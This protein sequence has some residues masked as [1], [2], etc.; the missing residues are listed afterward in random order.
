MTL[1]LIRSGLCLLVLLAA[2]R[3]LLEKEKMLHFNRA[4]LLFSL[5]FS[6]IVPFIPLTN[7]FQSAQRNNEIPGLLVEIDHLIAPPHP[8]AGTVLQPSHSIPVSAI[9][10]IAYCL[11]TLGFLIRFIRHLYLIR[12]RIHTNQRIRLKEAWLVLVPE[13]VVS[14]TFYTT[15]FINE[16]V[17]KE[18]RLEQEVLMHELAHVKQRH[19]ID[20]LLVEAL[21]SFF[22]FNPLLILYKR[23]IQLNHEF[24]ADEAVTAVCEDP[25]EYQYLLLSKMLPTDHL[26]LSSP[27]NYKIAKKRLIM[28]TKTYNKK[29]ALVKKLTV[30]PLLL[31][32]LFFFST[33]INAQQEQSDSSKHPDR[34][35]SGTEILGNN[36]Y[37]VINGK[38][39][40][41]DILMKISPA[42]ISSTSAFS[43]Q[44]SIRRYGPTASDGAVEIT[45]VKEG[46]SYATPTER[47]N[48]AKERAV[49]TG[50]YHRISLKKED[51]S[52]FDELIINYPE[53]KG[54][55]A[56]WG[57]TG[58]KVGFLV[59]DKLYTEDQIGELEKLLNSTKRQGPFGVGGND[60]KKVPGLDLSSYK[61]IFYF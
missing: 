40:P 8:A 18:Q 12:L 24:L 22:W 59:G 28:I 11:V 49:R 9:L 53:S 31:A 1:Y 57:E 35:V 54:R 4:W 60:V 3:F 17:Y 16:A 10:L 45:T 33:S 23:A 56:S 14:H 55:L 26:A 39:Y 25:K 27:L 51:G 46:I 52:S 37:V 32:A 30:A 21:Q 58:C 42:C 47:D 6:F 44:E 43:K 36:P 48:L 34:M 15:I 29:S 5:I 61:I 7:Y 50:F 20:V 38:Q 19:T 41:P 2:Y 13:E